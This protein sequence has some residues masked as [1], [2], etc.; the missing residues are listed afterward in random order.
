[1]NLFVEFAVCVCKRVDSPSTKLQ[2]IFISCASAC[3]LW[4]IEVMHVEGGSI[5]LTVDFMIPTLNIIVCPDYMPENTPANVWKGC[6]L[7]PLIVHLS[8]F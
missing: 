2:V 3:S 6:A 4:M 5:G 8:H 7:D 1:M